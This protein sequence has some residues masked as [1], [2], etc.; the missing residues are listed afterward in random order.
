M[1]V[2]MRTTLAIDDSLLGLA[3]RRAR[4]RGLTLGQ[5]VE[6][7][8]RQALARG[9][10]TGP[11]PEVPVFSGGTGLRPGVDATSNRSLLESMDDGTPLEELR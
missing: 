1:I 2:I 11:R 6:E 3:K 10:V 4:A 9:P 5:Y 7:A 8:L